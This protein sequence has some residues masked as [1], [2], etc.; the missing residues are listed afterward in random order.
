[1]R[2]VSAAVTGAAARGPLPPVEA[3]LSFS[4]AF[5]SS[6]LSTADLNLT[7]RCDVP[8]RLLLLSP[9]MVGSVIVLGGRLTFPTPYLARRW[10]SRC[11]F[12]RASSATPTPVCVC[13]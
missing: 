8:G 4:N 3:P 9:S 11:A 2:P 10:S 7:M 1:M 5:V 12:S 13:S 6:T